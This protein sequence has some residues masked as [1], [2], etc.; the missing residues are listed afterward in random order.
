[1]TWE[2]P[3]DC[4]NIQRVRHKARVKPDPCKEDDTY[5]SVSSSAQKA[6]PC[7]LCR[8]MH[9]TKTKTVRFARACVYGG[10]TSPGTAMTHALAR[11]QGGENHLRLQLPRIPLP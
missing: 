7:A 2:A 11:V 1:M 3:S 9:A 5:I 4:A 8:W 10:T 6:Y